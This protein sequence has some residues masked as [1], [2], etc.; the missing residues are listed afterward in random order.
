M[1]NKFDLGKIHP[2]LKGIEVGVKP[3]EELAASEALHVCA[4]ADS[5]IPAEIMIPGTVKAKCSFCSFDVWIAPSGQKLQLFGKNPII[6]VRCAL[7][8]AQSEGED[9]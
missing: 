1:S 7:K 4:N 6:C 8:L 2:K 3:E 9:A 5:S